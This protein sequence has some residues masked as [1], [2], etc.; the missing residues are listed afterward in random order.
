MATPSPRTPLADRIEELLA[1]GG[2]LPVV[3]AGAPVLRS[4]AERYDGQLDPALLARFPGGEGRH[5]VGGPAGPHQA[6]A[7]RPRPRHR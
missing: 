5:R 3:A 4:G 7:R 1:P 6:P 2:P